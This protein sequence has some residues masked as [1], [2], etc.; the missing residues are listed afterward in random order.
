VLSAVQS[1]CKQVSDNSLPQQYRNSLYDCAG[2]AP[3]TTNAR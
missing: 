2:A 1:V 3:V